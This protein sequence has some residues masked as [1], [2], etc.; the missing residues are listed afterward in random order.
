M[1]IAYFDCFSGISGDMCI[2]A[3]VDAGV[4]LQN[5]ESELRKIPVGAYRLRLKKVVRAGIAASKI[6]VTA[7]QRKT[8]PRAQRIR[9]WSDIEKL[10][11]KSSL[12]RQIK[13]RGKGIFRTLFEA[14]AKVH[15][16]SINSVHLHEIGALDCV[17]DIF[18]TLIGLDLLG[19][20]RV[21][22]SPVNL[23]SGLANTESGIYPVPPPAVSEILK[24]APVYGGTVNSELTTPTGAAI[25]K[26]IS[27]DFRSL[28]LMD[29][30]T[31][32][33][34]AGSK[35]FDKW[36]NVLRIFVGSLLQSSHE[37]DD[38]K[39]VVIETNI[40][41]MNPQIF[42][43][44]IERLYQAGAFDVY[45]AQVIMK[46][47]RPGILMTVLCDEMH[48]GSLIEIILKETST[49]GVRFFEAERKILQRHIEVIDTEFGKMRLKFSK[50][51]EKL[52]KVTPEYE[53]CKRIA[54][55]FKIPLLE[56]M[57]SIESEKWNL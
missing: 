49:I 44:A 17:I 23:G 25:I 14:E 45:L 50:L 57:R 27:S 43:Y 54:R 56:V 31:I 42:E 9:K 2:G 5:I 53:D 13:Q 33:T 22:S 38:E 10:V 34:G 29:I 46:K 36:P 18:G 32:G 21:F 15:G 8:V 1:K 41:D 47:G 52:L 37:C 20:E 6:D 7:V 51:G 11:N 39:V 3:L 40:D 48:K 55:K 28:P 35:D 12:T 30:E 4:S 26:E 24:Q 16:E 19:I